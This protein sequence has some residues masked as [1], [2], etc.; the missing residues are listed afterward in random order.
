MI[1]VFIYDALRTPRGKG[2]HSGS[3]Y[4]VKPIKLLV[5]VLQ[6]LQQ[7]HQLDT[8]LI[9]DTLIGC[10]TPI[11]DQGGNI[12][13]TAVAYAGWS[14]T[15]PGMQLNR[16]CASGL[17]AVNLAAMKI[18]S[19]WEKLIVAGGIE[20]MSRVPIATDG[21]ANMFDPAVSIQIGY[22]PQ[23][24][25]ADLIATIYGISR[26][27][28]DNFAAQSHQKA[29]FARENGHFSK[30][31]VPIYD[32]N[33]LIILEK[34]EIIHPNT[35]PE[36]LATLPLAFKQTGSM[37]YETLALQQYPLVEKIN[38]VHTAGNSSALADGAAALLIG[39]KSMG[40][41]TGIKPRARIRAVATTSSEPTI[42]LMGHVPAAQKALKVAGLTP[43]D[44]DLW[45]VNEAFAA[46]TLAFMRA[47]NLNSEQVNVVGGAI[48][49]G[50]PLGAT[51][52]I[53]IGTLLDELERRNLK[54]GLVVLCVGGG[55]GVATIV[56][57]VV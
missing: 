40:K 5:A 36:I 48:A 7:R 16:L 23:G 38:Y 28:V 55:M 8:T 24:V 26:E 9:D 25:A 53:L 4:E 2:K 37:G 54:R 12:A 46:P 30:S 31:I 35:T 42:M 22:I 50:H 1:E 45:E 57:M 49:L 39:D 56:E 21:G 33:G 18:S 32:D 52:A 14:P 44:I 3:L 51:G 20:S 19:G 11:G 15:V 6:A 34:D 41:K 27:E 10:V 47:F 17:D 29:A 43:E 13:K